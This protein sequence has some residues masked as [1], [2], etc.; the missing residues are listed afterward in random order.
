MQYTITE[1]VRQDGALAIPFSSVKP[2]KGDRFIFINRESDRSQVVNHA[3]K[4]VELRKAASKKL[5]LPKEQI[6]VHRFTCNGFLG[7]DKAEPY[8][9]GLATAIQS[10]LLQTPSGN[11]TYA[12]YCTQSRIARPELYHPHKSETWEY[13]DADFAMFDQWKSQSFGTRADDVIFTVLHVGTPKEDRGYESRLG[14]SRKRKRHIDRKTG[15]K[16]RSEAITLG[17]NAGETVRLFRNKYR[18][19]LDLSTVQKWFRTANCQHKPGHP[20]G[21]KH[22]AEI[23]MGQTRFS[24]ENAEGAAL[25]ENIANVTTSTSQPSPEEAYQQHFIQWLYM[26]GT[27]LICMS[28]HGLVT[29]FVNLARIK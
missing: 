26:M 14:L 6:I 11:K 19:E 2:T 10:E 27:D 18:V 5:R 25:S 16:L 28:A 9:K 1:T 23:A 29:F 20:L 4:E 3:E 13:T 21:T 7:N 8:Y 17:T 12:V 15:N 24:L 22:N